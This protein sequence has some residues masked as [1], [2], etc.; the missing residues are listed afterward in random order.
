MF[1]SSQADRPTDTD[2]TQVRPVIIRQKAQENTNQIMTSIAG[3]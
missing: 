3:G 1:G 2:L